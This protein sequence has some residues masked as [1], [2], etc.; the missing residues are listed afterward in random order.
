MDSVLALL[1]LLQLSRIVLRSEPVWPSGKALASEAEGPRFESAS[2]LFSL[3]KVVDCGHP[4]VT[5]PLTIT[6]TLQ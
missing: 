6:E 1:L 4:L 2:A 3:E 5:L